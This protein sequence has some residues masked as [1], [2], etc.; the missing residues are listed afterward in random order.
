MISGILTLLYL[1]KDTV[2]RWFTR[3]SSPLARVLVV[4]FLTLCALASLGSYVISTKI[5]RDKIIERGGDMVA[6]TIS[7][8][9]DA[10]FYLPRQ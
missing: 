1:A 2:H 5:V 10:Y 6:A 4:Y 9:S 8:R 3:I 7:G